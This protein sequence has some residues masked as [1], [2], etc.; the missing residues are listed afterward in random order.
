MD[1]L[2]ME[3]SLRSKHGRKMRGNHRLDEQAASSG[4]IPLPW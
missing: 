2:A 3:I 4:K 1:N